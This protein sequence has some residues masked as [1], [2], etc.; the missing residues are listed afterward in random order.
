M[1]VFWDRGNQACQDSQ[2]LVSPRSPVCS[3]RVTLL[4]IRGFGLLQ[5]SFL[6]D[7]RG[8]HSHSELRLVFY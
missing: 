8:T 3:K 1:A 6:T 5:V 7:Q 4:N 2:L